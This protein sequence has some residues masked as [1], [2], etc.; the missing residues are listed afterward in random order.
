MK[1]LKTLFDGNRAWVASKLESNP[2]FFSAVA[3][4]QTPKYLW[5]G[6]SDS[7]VAAN[8]VCG[9]EPGEMFV[10]RNVA[11][12]VSH[13][14]FNCL[15]VVQYAV[16]VLRVTD[17]IVC[18]H[19][20]CGG[21]VAT[22]D[23]QT[24]GLINNWLRHIHD[25]YHQHREEILALPLPKRSDR[26]CELNVARQVVN[27]CEATIVQDAW[28]RGQALSVHGWVYRLTDG[29]IRDLDLCVSSAGELGD[30]SE[31]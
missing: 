17:I 23:G 25:V 1:T 15:A 24:R 7:R 10:H 18:G 2:I 31:R 9:L 3:N 14:D 13:T 26:L 20:G 6:C 28:S 16:E 11:N 12:V 21:I 30:L 19:Y 4:E 27:L 8:E 22:L 29:L 5:F